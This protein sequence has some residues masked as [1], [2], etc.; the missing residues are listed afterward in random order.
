[1]GQGQYGGVGGQ[2]MSYT[3]EAQ[4]RVHESLTGCT[5]C[6]RGWFW[7]GPDRRVS[8]TGH[9]G[10]MKSDSMKSSPWVVQAGVSDAH[11]KQR[12]FPGWTTLEEG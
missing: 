7:A 8:A 9:T 12:L 11:I 10:M 6:N 1:M 5:I 4:C 2:G 3:I